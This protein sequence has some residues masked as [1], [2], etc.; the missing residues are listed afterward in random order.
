MKKNIFFGLAT[1]SVMLVAAVA[2]KKNEGFNA[3]STFAGPPF[4]DTIVLPTVITSNTTLNTS[5]LYIL[6]GK[7]YVSNNSVLTI[8]AGTHLRANKFLNNDSASA[9]VVTRGSK[10]FAEGTQNNPILFTSNQASPASGDWGGIVLLGKAPLN[11]ADTSIEGIDL[12]TVPP[13]VDV[14]YGG[15]GQ[16]LGDTADCSGRVS[17]VRIEYAGA[18]IS[19][20][21]ELNGLTCGG[22]GN[23]TVLDHIEVYKGNDDAFEF[24][25]G[26]VNARFLFAYVPD[27]DAFDFDFG[28]NGNIQ[29]AVSVLN[30][31][32]TYSANP[33]GIESDNNNLGNAN[34][35]RT[36]AVLSNLTVIGLNTNSDATSK[37]LLDGA[38]YRRES[39]YELRNS[40]VMG[41]P[42]G[43]E[44][45]G[46]Y[47]QSIFANIHHSL[48]HG[49]TTVAKGTSPTTT[50]TLVGTDSI[51]QSTT[52]TANSYIKLADP[53]A[54]I[55]ST[56]DFRP[57][58]GSPA[59][60]L[61]P[62]FAGLPST[63]VVGCAIAAWTFTSTNYVGAFGAKPTSGNPNT[64][65]WLIG[66]WVRF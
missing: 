54:A 8:P 23:G 50:I 14:E 38:Q 21:N 46:A 66:T 48:V 63:P 56:P 3:R 33:N 22:V 35:P 2:C 45:Q 27:D 5:I 9:L 52:N 59:L 26:N 42:T 43:I 30:T 65:N 24:F 15:G 44:L 16:G 39:G 51:Y 40:I 37:A 1:A 13:G 58:T 34:L 20:D 64:N 25:G 29:F 17:F 6:N 12:P 47:P 49:F 11:R 55:T 18:T 62:N 57:V 10:L 53:F 31:A 36:G 19:P 7:T 61:V 41:F 60:A 4:T 28:Y 32:E